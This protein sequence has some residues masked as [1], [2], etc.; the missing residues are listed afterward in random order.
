[1]C[2]R[3]SCGHV[4]KNFLKRISIPRFSIDRASQLIGD[5][6]TFSDHISLDGSNERFDIRRFKASNRLA[7]P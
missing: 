6:I 1:M 4:L 2:L 5:T 7:R 3:L